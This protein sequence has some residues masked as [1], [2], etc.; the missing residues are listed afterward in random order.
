MIIDITLDTETI[1]ANDQVTAVHAAMAVVQTAVATSEVIAALRKEQNRI[2]LAFGLV[3]GLSITEINLCGAGSVWAK[4]RAQLSSELE[5]QA[6]AAKQGG[7]ANRKSCDRAANRALNKAGF[8]SRVR[9]VLTDWLEALVIA[10]MEHVAT[11]EGGKKSGKV[12]AVTLDKVVA[13]LGE[14]SPAAKAAEEHFDALFVKR[15]GLELKAPA[16]GLELTEA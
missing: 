11:R 16:L 7:F 6:K 4:A 14:G 12:I 2:V 13:L 3:E 9:V 8:K 5:K 10:A 1:E 15:F